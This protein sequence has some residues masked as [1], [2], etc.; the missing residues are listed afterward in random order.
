MGGGWW[1]WGQGG[2][3]DLVR[4]QHPPHAHGAAEAAAGV[5]DADDAAGPGRAAEMDAEVGTGP[6]ASRLPPLVMDAYVATDGG[7][8][9]GAR[10]RR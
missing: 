6:S 8:G 7:D 5:A 1:E 4:E 2:R 10:E 3:V 9:D